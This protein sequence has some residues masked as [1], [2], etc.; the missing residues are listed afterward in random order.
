[1]STDILDS[2]KLLS[3]ADKLE[4]AQILWEDIVEKQDIVSVPKEHEVVLDE[5]LMKI[6]D[7][8]TSF[9]KWSSIRSKYE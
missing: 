6:E 7:G 3:L 8:K 4:V 5:R 2:L 1:M 9:N